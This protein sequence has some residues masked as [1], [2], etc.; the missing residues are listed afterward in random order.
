MKT[1]TRTEAQKPNHNRRDAP[2]PL[3]WIVGTHPFPPS[4]RSPLFHLS[5]DLLYPYLLFV[6]VVLD[7]PSR[8]GPHR[9]GEN[10]KGDDEEYA[11]STEFVGEFWLG[12]LAKCVI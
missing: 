4:V 3:R 8:Q 11:S 5:E 12:K 6:G 2:G 10:E 7:W 1:G 9:H